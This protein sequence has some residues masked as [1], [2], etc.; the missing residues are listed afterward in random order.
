MP[1]GTRFA[2]GGVTR[3]STVTVKA[4]SGTREATARFSGSEL[5]GHR[6]A[7]VRFL[8]ADNPASIVLV[9]DSGVRHRPLQVAA[10]KVK[11]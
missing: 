10:L 7:R 11:S 9:D 5:V 2:I 6:H 3:S 1:A 4:K 8:S